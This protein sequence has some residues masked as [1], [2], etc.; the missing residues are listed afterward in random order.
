MR[1]LSFRHCLLAYLALVS[2]L[3]SLSWQTL[4]GAGMG[5][6]M[7]VGQTSMMEMSGSC[8]GCSDVTALDADCVSINW[9][10]AQIPSVAISSSE[11]TALRPAAEQVALIPLFHPGLSPAPEPQPPRGLLHT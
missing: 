3:L 1:T 2:L 9:S 5:M 7:P 4:G 6:Q 11:L 8:D 10:C